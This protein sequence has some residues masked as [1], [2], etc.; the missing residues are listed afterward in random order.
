M[1]FF[2]DLILEVFEMGYCLSLNLTDPPR[3]RPLET[4]PVGGSRWNWRWPKG[5]LTPRYQLGT[6][7]NLTIGLLNNIAEEKH[8]LAKFLGSVQGFMPLD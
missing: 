8:L 6:S 5:F 2:P 7:E 1:T 4:L 3:L